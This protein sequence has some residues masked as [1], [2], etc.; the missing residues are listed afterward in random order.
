VA[1]GGRALRGDPVAEAV[2]LEVGAGQS[3]AVAELVAAAGYP[4]TETRRDLAA[5][6]RVVVGRR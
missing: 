4:R 1:L 2:A 3:A 6:E 5:I